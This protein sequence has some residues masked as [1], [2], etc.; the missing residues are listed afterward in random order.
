M[1]ALLAAPMLFYTA[2]LV[3]M[4]A[5]AILSGV[6][7]A[8]IGQG[9]VNLSSGSGLQTSSEDGPLVAAAVVVVAL[10]ATLGALTA[11]QWTAALRVP[12]LPVV[13]P[14]MLV[15]GA[16]GTTMAV[17][18]LNTLANLPFEGG[19]SPEWV[20]VPVSTVVWWTLL[21]VLLARHRALIR[22]G[23]TTAAW[24]V[25]VAATVGTPVV[26][27]AI[28][29]L[30]AGSD[31]PVTF[32]LLVGFTPLATVCTPFAFAL[33]RVVRHQGVTAGG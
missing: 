27:A 5:S 14:T 19:W 20:A 24:L 22:H 9:S 11:R 21:T 2:L 26:C 32:L 1:C 12:A 4:P 6:F 18:A 33:M 30:A 28:H 25:V 13:V 29:L 15:L 23:R 7:G 31:I 17:L 10:I 16:S 8:L 3:A